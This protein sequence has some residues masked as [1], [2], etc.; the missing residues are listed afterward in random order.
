MNSW[1]NVA[2]RGRNQTGGNDV[3]SN[4]RPTTPTTTLS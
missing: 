2:K 4:K 1:L 3:K